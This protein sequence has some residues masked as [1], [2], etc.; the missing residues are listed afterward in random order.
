MGE[1]YG[2]ES[3]SDL[4]KELTYSDLDIN[5]KINEPHFLIL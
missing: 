5:F 3:F 2:V 4:D 1:P